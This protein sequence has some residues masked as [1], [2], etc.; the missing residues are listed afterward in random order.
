MFRFDKAALDAA[1]LDLY[2]GTT[3]VVPKMIE[4]TSGFSP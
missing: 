1:L 3:L 4:N 2:Q